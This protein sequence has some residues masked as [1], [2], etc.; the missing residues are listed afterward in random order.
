MEMYCALI[1]K[2]FF[3]WMGF[4]KLT[5]NGRKEGGRR[6]A[7]ERVTSATGLCLPAGSTP[8]SGPTGR[9]GASCDGILLASVVS[10]LR[11]H[12]IADSTFSPSPPHLPGVVFVGQGVVF[13][14]GAAAGLSGAATPMLQDVGSSAAH[15]KTGILKYLV[16]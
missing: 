7:V 2:G 5:S 8:W 4:A 16:K 9:S 13:G 12:T 6:R 14:W 1:P 15:T 11:G 3:P 10:E